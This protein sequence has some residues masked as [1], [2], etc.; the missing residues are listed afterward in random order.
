MS[1]IFEGWIVPIQI[2]HPLVQFWIA[3]TNGSMITLEMTDVDWVETNDGTVR[4]NVE[5]IKGSKREVRI[6]FHCFL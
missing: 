4:V 5:G 6:S 1:S 3:L 2:L